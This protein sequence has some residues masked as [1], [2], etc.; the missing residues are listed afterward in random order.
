MP[1]TEILNDGTEIIIREFGPSEFE[2]LLRFY[3]NLPVDDRR[4]LRVDVTNRKTME[5]RVKLMDFGYHFRQ[6]ALDRNEIVGE[7]T[8][9]LPLRNGVAIRARF[10]FSSPSRSGGGG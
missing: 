4:Y 2:E 7:A 10:G 6:I 5:Q 3:G 9:E 1:K 8:L